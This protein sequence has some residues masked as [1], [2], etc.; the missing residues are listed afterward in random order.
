MMTVVV[1]G[2]DGFIGSSVVDSLAHWGASVRAI[3]GPPAKCVRMPSAE[4]EWVRAQITDPEALTKILKGADG[5]VHLAGPAS[6]RNSFSAPF[7]HAATHF[8]GTAA[9]LQ[10]G[11]NSGVRRFVYV[12]S[13]EVYSAQATVPISEDDPVEARSP[14]AAAKIGAEQLVHVFEIA[15]DLECV[16]LR[17]FSV[18]GPRQS[19]R[20]VMGTIIAQ[21]LTG[22]R[23]AVEDL[24]PIRDYVHVSDV[25]EACAR[26]AVGDMTGCT[27][28]NI[29]TGRGT[30]VGELATLVTRAMGST[31]RSTSRSGHIARGRSTFLA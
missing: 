10:A 1:S 5:I 31:F 19:E 20:T 2:A 25:A 14:Y 12:S 27:V 13:A 24:K 26:A 11:Q 15:Y 28:L 3:V 16:I 9:I 8:G 22:E 21:A 29:G 30:S 7:L 23:I 4:V 18:Y 6:V 17:P